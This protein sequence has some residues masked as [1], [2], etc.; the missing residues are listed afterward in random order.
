MLCQGC[1]LAISVDDEVVEFYFGGEPVM[2]YH[3]SCYADMG[4]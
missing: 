1:G 3:E 4:G 2:R